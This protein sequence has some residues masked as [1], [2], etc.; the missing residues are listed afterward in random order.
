M[1]RCR[2]NAAAATCPRIRDSL[3]P[4]RTYPK[5][6]PVSRIDTMIRQCGLKPVEAAKL[7]IG[8]P[9]VFI[10][11]LIGLGL[12][13]RARN[14]SCTDVSGGFFVP[15]REPAGNASMGVAVEL[16]RCA[17]SDFFLTCSSPRRARPRSS[18][19]GPPGDRL[20]RESGEWSLLSWKTAVP[21]AGTARSQGLERT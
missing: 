21:R 5:V 14:G 6:E 9:F 16:V 15:W 7:L 10:A 4:T 17:A 3:M 20:W 1:N 12:E 19:A 13:N 2:S 11:A 18:R 8:P